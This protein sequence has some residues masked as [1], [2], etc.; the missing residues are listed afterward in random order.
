MKRTWLMLGA[1]VALLASAEASAQVR[2][3]SGILVRKDGASAS[4]TTSTTTAVSE[5]D[6]AVVT[7]TPFELAPYANMNEKN[8]TAHMSASDSLELQISRLA[9]TKASNQRVRNYATMLVNDHSSHLAK[10][11]EIITDED[12]GAEP[13]SYDPEHVRMREVLSAL[14][15]RGRSAEWDAAF[16]RFQVMHHQNE[17]DLLTPVVKNA[18]AR[19]G[20][21]LTPTTPEKFAEII[22]ADV[23]KYAKAVKLA[24]LKPQ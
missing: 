8:M 11:I 16:L 12:V 19:L 10:T 3:G 23:D 22:R 6:V 15:A 1:G 14:R 17:I 5:G 2:A 20:L 7:L 24:G 18:H 13:L 4:T 21:E 9:Q